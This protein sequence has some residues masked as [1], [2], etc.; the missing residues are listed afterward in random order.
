MPSI[1]SLVAMASLALVLVMV[2]ARPV[3]ESRGHSDQFALVKGPQGARFQPRAFFAFNS[4]RPAYPSLIWA[5]IND[6][7]SKLH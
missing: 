3:P 5:D 4:S 2:G 7:L 1:A 6:N